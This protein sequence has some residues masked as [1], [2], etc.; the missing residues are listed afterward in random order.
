MCQKYNHI[1]IVGGD[2]AVPSDGF[3][4]VIEFSTN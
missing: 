4:L 3:G 1:L 2:G